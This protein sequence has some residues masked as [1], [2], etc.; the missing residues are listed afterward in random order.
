MMLEKSSYWFLQYRGYSLETVDQ[1]SIKVVM[2]D[3]MGLEEG[4]AGLNMKEIDDILEG[5]VKDGAKV[6]II[7]SVCNFVL[8]V[9]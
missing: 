9:L 5:K 4:S 8:K 2:C 3:S 6:R 7:C 1:K